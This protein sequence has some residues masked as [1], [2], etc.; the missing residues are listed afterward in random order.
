MTLFESIFNIKKPVIA[1]LHVFD[2]ERQKQIDQ[3]L[4]DLER[5]DLYVDGVIVENYDCGYFDSNLAT[6]EMAETLTE[7]TREVVRNSIIPVG[8]NVLPNDYKKA[9]Q[10]CHRTGADFI[11]LDHVTGE[12]MDCR[13]V[14]PQ[15]LITVRLL[16]PKIALLGGIHPKYYQLTE[17]NC[18]LAECAKKAMFL[19]DVVVVTGQI[20]GDPPT[21]DDLR[22]ARE[23]LG[24]HP[25]IIGSG[26]NAENARAQ[27][28]IADGAIVGTAFKKGGVRPGEP[29][30][31]E[32]VEKLMA[33]VEL[34]RQK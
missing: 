26:L 25:L 18:S 24:T 33:Q 21:L 14:D 30:D 16:Y 17:P 22:V 15:H 20:T 5:L 8:L 3:A 27:L 23:V 32:M 11:Q 2:G 7:I 13:P 29:I 31:V 9:F 34:V 28:A 6:E 4:E 12:F 1:M 19:A 10:I